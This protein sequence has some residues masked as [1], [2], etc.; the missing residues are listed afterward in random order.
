M[1]GK[2]QIKSCLRSVVRVAT[3][4][5][6]VILL[7]GG[8]SWAVRNLI[9]RPVPAGNLISQETATP[10]RDPLIIAI[11]TVPTVSASVPVRTPSLEQFTPLPTSLPMQ[12]I[13][14]TVKAGDTLAKIAYDHALTLDTLLQLNGLTPDN[15]LSPGQELIVGLPSI[16]SAPAFVTVKTAGNPVNLRSGPGTSYP[17]VGQISSGE[18]LQATGI[19]PNGSWIQL[20]FSGV[21]EGSA[22][23]Y[24]PLAEMSGGTLPIVET[25]P[26]ELTQGT[27]PSPVAAQP[28]TITLSSETDVPVRDDP[29]GELY[30]LLRPVTPPIERQLV[31]VSLPCLLTQSSCAASPVSGF[32]PAEDNHLSWSPDGTLAV[33]DNSG[34]AQFLSYDPETGSWKTLIEAGNFAA[35]MNIALWSPDGKWIATTIQ[36]SDPYTSLITLLGPLGVE[37]SAKLR[38][39]AS[40][41]GAMQIP[42]GW[43]GQESLLFLR[44]RPQPKGQQGGSIDP[45]LYTLNIRTGKSMELDYPSNWEW[46]KSYPVPSP[47]GTRLAVPSSV[48]GRAELVISDLANGRR[49]GIV[50]ATQMPVWSPDGRWLAYIT[51]AEMG[52]QEVDIFGFEG[53]SIRKVF[54]WPGI[55][56]YLWTPDSQHLLLVA[57]P[58][59]S[60]LPEGDRT[61]FYLYSLLNGSLKKLTLVGEAGNYEFL[62]PSFR[63]PSPP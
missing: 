20:V 45:R 50:G 36:A 5:G 38:S 41:L 61:Q 19:S 24:A 56:S 52:A 4:A 42:L 43:L 7:I 54:D 33:L 55:P 44:Y 13:T 21:P 15:L 14:Y 1:E 51:P 32:P 53:S 48:D 39:M 26:G 12:E 40:D 25:S 3:V 59:G 8:F 6:V 47:D 17:V 11:G 60:A 49:L 35:T 16:T 22:W 10:Q 29:S 18:R 28:V 63:P 37:D 57:Y 46:M 27:H 9:P 30:F 58:A 62:A 2:G 23:I 34:S 31:H